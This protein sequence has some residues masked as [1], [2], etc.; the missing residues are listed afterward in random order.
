MARKS[1]TSFS[2]P[3]P[4]DLTEANA[5]LFRLDALARSVEA[6]ENDYAE[7]V[8]KLRKQ[9]DLAIA[10]LA[11]EGVA[12]EKGLAVFANDNRTTLLTGDEKSV[13]LSGGTFGWRW[14]PLK[15]YTGK[16]GDTK[17]LATVKG[18]NL[19]TYVRTIESLDKEA[20]LRD[21]PV[22]PGIKYTQVE[23]FFVT[24][25]PVVNDQEAS[26]NVIRLVG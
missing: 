17:A 9:A 16:G 10:P 5:V 18:M 14:T 25:E 22:I 21:Q 15:V 13:K 26:L 3:V 7:A 6:I 8:A 2:L 19:M 12:L 20:L 1:R 4:A 11:G 23:N 24:P